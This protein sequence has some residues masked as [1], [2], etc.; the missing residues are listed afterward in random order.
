MIFEMSF[1]FFQNFVGFSWFPVSWV[2][3]VLHT[4][5]QCHETIR[6]LVQLN[7]MQQPS[8]RQDKK[9]VNDSV[10]YRYHDTPWP[11]HTLKTKQQ[12]KVKLASDS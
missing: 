1:L 11:Y 2:D 7:N 3:A 5:L 4:P 8:K 10:H 6:V 9:S 12:H